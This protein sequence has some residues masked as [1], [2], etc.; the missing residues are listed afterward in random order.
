MKRAY[1]ACPEL[2]DMHCG[3]LPPQTS[4][5]PCGNSWNHEKLHQEQSVRVNLPFSGDDT[6]ELH[7][8]LTEFGHRNA[9]PLEGLSVQNVQPTSTIHKDFSQLGAPNDWVDHQ[10]LPPRSSNVCWV[11][12]LVE[13]N[14]SLR[15]L[16]VRRS[17]RSNH[18][19]FSVDNL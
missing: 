2:H 10:R 14:G 17:C 11:I 4:T 1:A 18:A 8:A 6:V 9:H 3:N 15:P 5:S 13:C 19:H 7:V 16:Q 12:K